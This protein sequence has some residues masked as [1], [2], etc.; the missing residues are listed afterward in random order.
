MGVELLI[1]GAVFLATAVMAYVL[2]KPNIQ[3]PSVK[4]SGLDDFNIT[5]ASEG[6]PT[7]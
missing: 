1:A 4:A 2:Y 3:Q 7:Q 6:S 5:R